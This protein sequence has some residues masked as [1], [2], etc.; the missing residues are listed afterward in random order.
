MKSLYGK[1][2]K[3]MPSYLASE[4]EM[5]WYSFCVKNNIRISPYGIQNNTDQWK[6]A[7]SIGPY[8]RGEKPHLSPS[9]YD[10][11]TIWPEYYKMCEYYYN[12]YKN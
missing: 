7:I 8:K 1:R 10:R 12:K 6:I 3:P 4:E 5:K 11:N 2:A 9:T